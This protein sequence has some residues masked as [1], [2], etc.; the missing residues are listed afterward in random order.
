[1][2]WVETRPGGKHRGCYRDGSG[3]IRSKGGFLHKKAAKKWAV[4]QEETARGPGQFRDPDAGR[5]L[6]SEWA[7]KWWA[8]REVEPS[9]LDSDRARYRR[10]V[11]DWGDWPLG[12]IDPLELQQWVKTLGRTMAPGTVRKYHGLLSK[13][14]NDAML[15]PYRLVT[16]NPCRHVTL[17]PVN[18]GR[19]VFLTEA[20]VDALVT[21]LGEETVDGV[22]AY[23]LAYSGLRWGEAAGLHAD[24]IDWLRRGVNVAQTL[25][26][27]GQ[28]F[29]LKPYTKGRRGAAGLR[30]FVPLPQHVLD[31]LAAHIAAH[32]P[33]P[34]RLPTRGLD[35]KPHA[36]CPGLM[37]VV[38]DDRE[39]H[40]R[41]GLPLF[42][43]TWRREQFAAAAS[44]ARLPADVRPHDLRHTYA[45]WLVQ[46]GVSL[47]EV[48]QHLGHA[49][50]TTTE[51]YAH[52]APD[53]GDAARK[54]LERG[55]DGS[56]MGAARTRTTRSRRHAP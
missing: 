37:F 49:S 35:G 28:R 29:Y 13:M 34:C 26:Q 55:R 1:M 54:A 12:A 33:Q 50:I 3:R 20:Q 45:S 10:I 42:R 32:P 52:L 4:A 21:E 16:E 11:D 38:P 41:A 8:A 7:A 30:R 6:L 27:I 47:R 18:P 14:L 53:A 25:A 51:R 23:L 43:Q 24:Q 15:P 36:H 17:T 9:T 19:E 56:K 40:R 5:T 46:A 22:L 2:A 31:R 39:R 48:Q 44:R